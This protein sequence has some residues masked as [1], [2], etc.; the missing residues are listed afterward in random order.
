[1]SDVQIR[2]VAELLPE[3][4]G[5]T[6]LFIKLTE[7]VNYETEKFAAAIID[8]AGKYTDPAS[9]SREVVSEVFRENGLPSVVDILEEVSV[10]DHN[11]VLAFSAYILMFKGSRSGYETVLRL[12]GFDYTLVEWWENGGT[13]KPNTISIDVNLDTSVVARPYLTFQKIKK[14]TSEYVF[15][16]ID[17]LGFTITV[18]MGSLA[19]LHF[20]MAHPTY[21]SSLTTTNPLYLDMGL[22]EST[23]RI[24]DELLFSD[25]N[26]IISGDDSRTWNVKVNSNGEL[27][28][29]LQDNSQETE[30]FAVQRVD[31]SFVEIRVTA[32]GVLYATALV[33]AYLPDPSFYLIAPSGDKW[34]FDVQNDNSISTKL[35]VASLFITA[36]PNRAVLNWLNP[37]GSS[38]YNVFKSTDGVVFERIGEAVTSNT[39]TDGTVNN[40]VEY[41]YRI[42]SV[43][44][45]RETIVKR[46]KPISLCL[47]S[48]FVLGSNS[49]RVFW[50][51]ALG[52]DSYTIQ[53]VN[54]L[55]EVEVF[56]DLDGS[57]RQYDIIG[58]L[59]GS[60]YTIRIIG[61]NAV[62]DGTTII[63]G[64][65]AVSTAP[66]APT[67]L[68]YDI[69]S[70]DTNI[71]MTWPASPTATLYSIF[72]Q[73]VGGSYVEYATTTATFYTDTNIQYGLTNS[74]KVRAF[75]GT[76]SD[77]GPIL[78]VR[79]PGEFVISAINAV[80]DSTIFL[81][82]GSSQLANTYNIL[83]KKILDSVFTEQ[84]TTSPSDFISLLDSY[85]TYQVKI[86][87]TTIFGGITRKTYTP[88]LT[89]K[90]YVRE[91]TD[92][93][94]I[95]NEDDLQVEL[96]WT[97]AFGA[98]NYKV[99][100][101]T[102]GVNFTLKATTSSI[103][104]HDTSISSNV[105]YHYY[106]IS[107][108][109]EL[110]SS[111]QSNTVLGY[112]F[113]KVTD[114]ARTL[115]AVNSEIVLSWTAISGATSYKI[116]R[117]TVNSSSL[118]LYQTVLTAGYTDTAL[119]S[120][121]THWY[122]V[123]AVNSSGKNTPKSNQ[124]NQ[125]FLE[126]IRDLTT[127]LNETTDTITLNWSAIFGADS[128]KVYES[129]DGV[130]Y[131]QV[132]TPTA[133]TYNDVT[134]QS[135]FSNYYYVVAMDGVLSS[136]NSNISSKYF[137]DN[138]ETLISSIDATFATVSLSWQAVGGATS[139]KIYRSTTSSVSGFSLYDTTSLL[140]FEDSTLVSG[141]THY[142]KLITVSGANESVSSNLVSEFYIAPVTGLS[143]TLD[144]VDQT[145]TLNWTSVVGADN[146]KVYRS[147]IN[148]GSM[149]FYANAA[150][151]TYIDTTLT[152]DKTHYYY[153]VACKGAEVSVNSSIVSTYFLAHAT[154]LVATVDEPNAKISLTWSSIGG[155][156]SYNI[157]RSVVSDS[158]G[159]VLY[160]SSLTNAFDDLTLE[161]GETHWY[162]V[163]TVAGANL[164]ASSNVSSGFFLAAVLNLT[165]TLD[166]AND[167]IALSWDNTIGAAYYEIFRSIT[168]TGNL[169]M[170]DTSMSNSYEDLSLSSGD[171]HDY[172]VRAVK[173][174]NYG[175]FSGI[176][177][178]Y[179]LD[180]I[181]DLSIVVD[182]IA[183]TI[184]LTWTAV[185]AVANYNIYRSDLDAFSGFVF[186][187]SV[188]GTNYQDTALVDGTTYWYY[189][190]NESVS[191]QVSIASN[192]V[193]GMYDAP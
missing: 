134:L 113:K 124:V 182:N 28:P 21:V 100:R 149:T 33:G 136:I 63:L 97:A 146:Y 46:V 47:N 94:L 26:F 92:L 192:T 140:A 22:V 175:L 117:S 132:A 190:I 111:A 12:L 142:Y 52:A 17:P 71:K 158:S 20:G 34:A 3:K 173:S 172:K 25:T 128:Y 61:K 55:G 185:Q 163:V 137:L 66:S 141:E 68:V 161:S 56:Q 32:L 152:S 180:N 109:A 13:G 67:E 104:Y 106:V 59:A 57:F 133:I 69:S 115:N 121:E 75:N 183:A 168:G 178:K 139:Y 107:V 145:V 84:I 143:R 78:D 103:L 102:D 177:S 31:G 189:V 167:K 50:D 24:P 65:N 116:Y 144:A 135:G 184:D 120:G 39:L 14:F 81:T 45:P 138:V 187:A 179:F 112:Y 85:N 160:D 170:Y 5:Q 169:A 154:D 83:Y 73:T 35:A 91:I 74:Y 23:L 58:L 16:I 156:T 60:T 86:E 2:N 191:A 125:Y 122:H 30:R 181:E 49:V 186:Q 40:G 165:T 36:T 108:D 101:S 72:R 79:Q 151:N 95:V 77:F 76:Y 166:E 1:M 41:W 62:G 99:Y 4:Q 114:L 130:S 90:T 93:S 37:Y 54:A 88:V 118:T 19:W 157:M 82:Y 176:S 80:D 70:A 188:T 96:A 162:K 164:S 126:S 110:R 119:V 64:S 159:F 51:G 11:T 48:A 174:L 42:N 148:S 147:T 123:V 29:F 27:R 44:D 8:V 105:T 127:T 153:V 98:V 171:T 131:A 6:E 89:A 193:T 7:M 155:A 150:T 38:T 129:I 87:S 9:V 15:P 18:N 43:V 10:I 53:A